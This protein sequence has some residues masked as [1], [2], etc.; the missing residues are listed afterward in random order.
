MT[1]FFYHYHAKPSFLII[2][3]TYTTPQASAFKKRSSQKQKEATFLLWLFATV[4]VHVAIIETALL[5]FA[6]VQDA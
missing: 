5:L 6:E 3:G 4:E 1:V 2:T